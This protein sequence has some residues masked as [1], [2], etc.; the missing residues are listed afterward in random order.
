MVSAHHGHRRVPELCLG[1]CTPPLGGAAPSLAARPPGLLGESLTTCQ[2]S[3]VPLQM[4]LYLSAAYGALYFLATLLMVTYKSKSYKSKSGAERPGR[5]VLPRNLSSGLLPTVCRSGF[6]LSSKSPG[7][8]PDS[9]VPAGD[10]GS[11]SLVLG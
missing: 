4:M 10:S 1:V 5:A 8:R 3:S 6:Q 2:L 9:A 7:P 11:N